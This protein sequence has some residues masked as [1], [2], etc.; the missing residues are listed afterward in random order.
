VIGH[1]PHIIQPVEFYKNG[2]VLY[3]LGNFLFDQHEPP[4][5]VGVIF[6]CT[7]TR[8]GIKD[9]ALIPVLTQRCRPGYLSE[10]KSRAIL[11]KIRIISSGINIKMVIK[12]GKLVL[13][14]IKNKAK[15]IGKKTSVIK[16]QKASKT[17]YKGI[18]QGK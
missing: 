11:E 1:H 13:P 14:E 17:E 6:E 18:L 8:E 2:I 16:N 9:A 15:V 10:E 3:S 5:N 4:G 12:D 7:F